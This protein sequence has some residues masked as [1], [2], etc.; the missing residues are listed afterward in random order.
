LFHSFTLQHPHS[1]P[2]TLLAICPSFATSFMMVVFFFQ[3]A[4]ILFAGMGAFQM[5]KFSLLY[6]TTEKFV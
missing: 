2:V 3:I 4:V 1:H 5:A 6:I